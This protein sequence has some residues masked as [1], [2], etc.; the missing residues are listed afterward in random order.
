MRTLS[1]LFALLVSQCCFAQQHWDSL[2]ALNRYTTLLY[3]DSVSDKLYVCGQFSRVNGEIIRGVA[4][5]DGTQLDSLG[6]G[7]DYDTIVNVYPGNSWAMVRRDSCLYL[8]GG[9][10]S[11]GYVDAKFLARWNGSTWDTIPGGQPNDVVDG[12]I[13]YNNDIYISGVFDSVGNIPASGIAKW[14]GASWSAIGNNFPFV[15][16]WTGVIYQMEFYHGN[17]FVG[18]NFYDPQG[19]LCYLAKWDGIAWE[20]LGGDLQCGFGG[21]ADMAV[22]NDELY[23]A[24]FF[25][26]GGVNV[27]TS[28]MRWNDTLWRDVAGSVQFVVNNYPMVQKMTV[29]NGKLYCA[30]NFEMIGN[31]PALGLASWDGTNW[32]GYGTDF[33]MQSQ[34]VG[35]LCLAF[36]R[37]TLY[38]G[39]NF[40]EVEG[41]TIKF[42]AQWVG[43]SFVD[44]C[45]TAVGISDP[46]PVQK[47]VAVYP[48]PTSSTVTFQFSNSQHSRSIIIYDHLGREISREE[49]NDN[50]I[51]ISVSDFA[52]GIY[53]YRIQDTEGNKSNG[54]FVVVY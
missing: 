44:T 20:F 37:D 2:G 36:F 25:V 26:E 5:W 15:T 17:L 12:M 21:I 35:A 19:N 10:R 13:L 41:D 30:G 53:F 33:T 52:E 16:A 7:I 8:A 4:T 45:G 6:H 14:D 34:Y 22:Y 51:S 47:S 42:I 18:G 50:A 23:V 49:T 46:D 24:G 40:R 38:I 32:C 9:F 27:A 1:L 54:K 48:N 3:G 31:V 28:I 43:G 39:G 29:H 11:A